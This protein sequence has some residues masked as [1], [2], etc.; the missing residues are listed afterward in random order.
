MDEDSHSSRHQ[1]H[2]DGEQVH[3]YSA[4]PE[5]VEETRTHLQAYGKHEKNQPEV[6]DE[7][8]DGGVGPEAEVAEQDSY[9]KDPGGA[10]AYALYLV[11]PQEKPEGYHNREQ[12]HGMCD[13]DACKQFR[14]NGLPFVFETD[15]DGNLLQPEVDEVGFEVVAYDG[16]SGDEIGRRRFIPFSLK[17]EKLARERS[18]GLLRFGEVDGVQTAVTAGESAVLRKVIVADNVRPP[19]RLGVPVACRTDETDER[20]GN[21][22][23]FGDDDVEFMAPDELQ[24]EIHSKDV[25]LGLLDGLR[26]VAQCFGDTLPSCA[27]LHSESVGHFAERRVPEEGSGVDVR[28]QF[29]IQQDI[30]RKGDYFVEFGVY[31]VLHQDGTGAALL[32]HTCI[33]GQI[34][35]DNLHAGVRLASVVEGV[36]GE[37]VGMG[38]RG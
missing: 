4:L 2:S 30:A 14:H 25:G 34:D 33:E 27:L 36:A 9:E 35:G 29:G 12:Q 22:V 20:G 17:F 19:E 23:F 7:S 1:H 32:L 5:G 37:D 16:I 15:V 10:Y 8:E 18:D 31:D 13:T 24:G 38:S 6:L 26:L 3:R 21:S 11:T 28:A